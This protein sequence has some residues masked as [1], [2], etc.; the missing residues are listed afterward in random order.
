MFE[1]HP[2]DEKAILSLAKKIK[3]LDIEKLQKD[4]NSQEI[5]EKFFF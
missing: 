3:G 5:K 1:H 2:V 4:A